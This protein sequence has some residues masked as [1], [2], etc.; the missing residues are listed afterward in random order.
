MGSVRLLEGILW[1]LLSR[2]FSKMPPSVPPSS[3]IC[4][5]TGGNGKGG[6]CLGELLVLTVV[7][8][9]GISRYGVCRGSGGRSST[10]VGSGAG[11]CSA[12]YSRTN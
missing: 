5:L 1:V 6:V 7:V 8:L 3:R 10:K 4:L 11:E 2:S 9:L 12:R